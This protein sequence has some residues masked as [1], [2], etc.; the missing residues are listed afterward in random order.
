MLDLA[1]L[2][3]Q[4]PGISQHLQ[5]EGLASIKRLQRANELLLQVSSKQEEFVELQQ[6]WHDRFIFA[7]ATPIEPVHTPI[8]ISTPTGSHTVFSTDGSQIS[9]SHHEVTYCYL[10]NIGRIMLHYGQS[11]FPLLDS[12]PEVFYKPE[13]I[14][15]SKQWGIKVEEWMGYRRTVSEAQM[16][17]EMACRWVRPPGSHYNVPNLAMV[18][19]SLILWFLENLPF[20]WEGKDSTSYSSCLGRITQRKHSFNGL[21]ER[22]SQHRSSQFSSPPSLYFRAS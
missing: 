9:P 17:A 11:L 19:G 14:Y 7:A 12:I 16:L 8:P 4:I 21:R 3:G 1:K 2:A 13:D 18:D 20:R 15:V 5:Q 6:E 22:F 10:I